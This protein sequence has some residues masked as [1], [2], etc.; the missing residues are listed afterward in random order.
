D[1]PCPE[2]Q[3]C[4]EGQCEAV[5]PPDCDDIVCA[6]GTTCVE[7]ACVPEPEGDCSD[8]V[9]CTGAG[10]VCVEGLCVV[11]ESA[12]ELVLV[13]PG[14]GSE[15]GGT[16]VTLHGSG[17]LEGATVTF[18]GVEAS[19][20]A[21]TDIQVAATTPA[22]ALGPVDVTLTNPDGG[23]TTYPEGFTYVEAGSA[24]V[25]TSVDPDTGPS[26][27][28]TLVT[29]FGANFAPG[30]TVLFGTATAP[31]SEVAADGSALSTTTPEAPLGPVTV[32][33]VNPDGQQGVLFEG[34]TYSP[35]VPDWG[36]LH[37]PATLDVLADVEAVTLSAEVWEP[38]LTEV[39][40]P[41]FGLVAQAGYGPVGSLPSDDDT[42]TWSE[43]A[44]SHDLDNNDVW[45]GTVVVPEGTWSATMRFSLGTDTW[46]VVDL[47][48]TL[49]GASVDQFVTLEASPSPPVA[50]TTVMPPTSWPLGG[51]TITLTGVGLE[52]TCTL[53]L[54][55][56]PVPVEWQAP[57]LTFAAPAHAVGEVA[58]TLDCPLGGATAALTYMESWDGALDEWPEST[59]IAQNT[60]PSTW[61]DTNVLSRLQV[62]ASDSHLYLGVEGHAYGEFGMNAIVIYI[63]AD[64]GAATG[65]TMTSTLTDSDHPVDDALGGALEL[66]APGFGAEVALATLDMSD[67]LPGADDDG[68]PAG[69]RKLSPPEDLPWLSDGSII[70]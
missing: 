8:Q 4:V 36:Q 62:A 47:D 11:P 35:N 50:V 26:T 3:T 5:E 52:E 20:D 56:T 33:V 27:G 12:P 30:A 65:L 6:E 25:V 54:D 2:G 68:T 69:W 7:G 53:A 18:G 57:S 43:A 13:M 15:L 66:T 51:S 44:F 21:M 45:T 59:A 40:G 23:Q 34:Y 63:D 39:E 31:S 60:L 49:D 67:D 58:L 1:N 41:G 16:V 29:V 38:G 46:L 32:T 17:F 55:G 10:E 22:H 48:G 42:W 14:T 61:S 37:G 24:P 70:A 19:I 28:G 9:P 64:L